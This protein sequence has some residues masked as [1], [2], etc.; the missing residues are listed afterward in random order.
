[1]ESRQ[2]LARDG[3]GRDPTDCFTGRGAATPLPV[4]NSV[5]G[6]VGKV[7]MRRAKRF[8]HRAIIFRARVFVPDQNGDWCPERLAFE[9]PGKNFAAIGFLARRDDGALTWPAAIEFTLNV[10]LA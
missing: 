9:D 3:A 5:F 10:G 1:M 6:F 8:L 2:D 7:G 4:A